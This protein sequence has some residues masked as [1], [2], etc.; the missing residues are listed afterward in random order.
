MNYYERH[1]GDYLKD[2]SHLSLLEHG[3]Y[4]RLMDVY[5][6]K[7]SGIP[8]ADVARL[9]GARSKEEKQALDVVL[10]EF[11]ILN[12]DTYKQARCDR[13]ITRFKDKQAKAQRSANARWKPD[14]LHTEGNAKAMRTHT[15]GNA[16]QTPDTSN[17]TPVTSLKTE[18]TGIGTP[19]SQAAKVCLVVK[20][21]GV[22]NT[23][24]GHPKLI[25]L[26]NDGAQVSDFIAAAKVTVEAGKGFAYL[27]GV[28]KG[29]RE[30]AQRA[31][32]VRPQA[33]SFAERDARVARERWEQMTGQTHPENMPKAAATVIDAPT[34]VLEISQ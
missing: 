1:I 18:D 23:N 14:S 3:V 17:Q 13:E 22:G 8:A 19:A 32:K 21:E 31:P 6:T 33:E 7:E 4:T 15:E 26:L 11:F 10:K 16:H 5:Y 12:V 27:L 20:A 29:M 24:P 9:I 30:D 28:V 25:D 2:T 34:Q